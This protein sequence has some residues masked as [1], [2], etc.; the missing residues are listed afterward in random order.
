[1]GHVRE[2]DGARA[3]RRDA[4]TLR[5]GVIGAGWVA[6]DRHVPAY[7]AHPHA[8]VVALYDRQVDRARDAAAKLKIPN[9]VSDV[10]TLFDVGVDIVSICTPPWTHPALSIAASRAGAHVFTEKPMA[11]NEGD[12]CAMADAA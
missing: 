8:D 12:A 5:V 10:Q 2:A 3:A 4:M 11:M 6:V 7:R 1:M 9:A